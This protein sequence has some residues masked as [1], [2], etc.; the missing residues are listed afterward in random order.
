MWLALGLM[1]AGLGL[2]VW[3]C[4]RSERQQ[5]RCGVEAEEFERGRQKVIAAMGDPYERAWRKMIGAPLANLKTSIERR[6]NK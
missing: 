3:S 5:T 1:A 2:I 4:E 6:V